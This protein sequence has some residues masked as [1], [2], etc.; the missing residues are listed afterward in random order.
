MR[1][2]QDIQLTLGR[3]AIEDIDLDVRSRDDI[4]AI[5]L[6]VRFLHCSEE[7]HAKVLR[8]LES[9]IVGRGEGSENG[10]DG[11]DPSADESGKIKPAVGRPGL[12]L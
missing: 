4:P 11:S 1:S 3:S 7:L 8:L 12:Q 6:G 9:R 10:K 5:L 2:V